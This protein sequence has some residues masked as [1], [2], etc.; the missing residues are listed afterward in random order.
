[1]G[2][3]DYDPIDPKGREGVRRRNII[4]GVLVAVSLIAVT[5]GLA[6]GLTI[7]KPQLSS[8]ITSENL[9]SHLQQLE[10]IARNNSNSRAIQLG[11]NASVE[12]VVQTITSK[13]GWTPQIQYFPVILTN[14]IE[15]AKL[16][17]SSPKTLNFTEGVDFYVMSDYNG[18]I[19]ITGVLFSVKVLGCSDGDFENFPADAVALIKR[20]NCTFQEKVERALAFNASGVLIYN[21][22]TDASRT[23]VFAGALDVVGIPVFSLSYLTGVMLTVL[24]NAQITLFDHAEAYIYSTS[25]VIVDTPFGDDDEIV[26]VGSHLD[27]VPKGP[28]MDDNGSGSCANLEL[29]IQLKE[30]GIKTKNKIRFAW[31][32]AEEKG[33]LGSKY[34]VQTLPADELKKIALNLNFDMIAAPNYMIGV[35]NGSAAPESCKAGSY[36]IQKVIEKHLKENDMN[37]KITGFSGRSDYGPFINASIP[38]NGI[39]TGAEVLKTAEDQKLFG[40]MQNVP[41]DPCYH[42]A[43]DDM[44]NVNV[45]VFTNI[46]RVAAGVL[47]ELAER[48]NLKKYL[49]EGKGPK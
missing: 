21:D 7:K 1:M 45:E 10:D 24:P 28:G 34:Y 18:T 36:V 2:R 43:C 48:S 14:Q 11:Y 3:S 26:V 29:A 15:P 39:E 40:G 4:I 33:L 46:A 13:T 41:Y 20:G 32:G 37:W 35:H 25:N 19:S 31:W 5:I 22:G 30:L 16:S 12:Y 8:R 23:G 49:A 27:S 44:H 47:Q 9:L 38:A 6:V 42:D 17:L